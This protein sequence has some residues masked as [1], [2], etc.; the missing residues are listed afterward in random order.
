[1]RDDASNFWTHGSGIGTLW[2]L[3][4][5]QW[6][7]S[8]ESCKLDRSC[9][10]IDITGLHGVLESLVRDIVPHTTK[11]LIELARSV[12]SSLITQP[13]RDGKLR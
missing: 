4:S 11:F 8:F 7:V 10:A 9:G 13:A 2:G 12:F 1:M 6:R 5:N 3:D